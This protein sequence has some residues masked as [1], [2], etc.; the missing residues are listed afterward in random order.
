[1]NTLLAQL[2]SI[3]AGSLTPVF[4]LLIDTALKGSL[5]IL[6]AAIAAYLLRERSAAARHAAW[7]AAVVGHLALPVL[8]LLVPQWRIPILP[9]PPWLDA[10]AATA[11]QLDNRSPGIE[12]TSALSDPGAATSTDPQISA[13]TPTGPAPLTTPDNR[14]A[15]PVSTGSAEIGRAHV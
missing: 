4:G 11:P 12:V 1:M 15:S 10:P 14:A 6:A 13:G 3:K 2:T 8:T 7:S 9:A 5:L